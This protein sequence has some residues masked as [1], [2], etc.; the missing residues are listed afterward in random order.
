M[1]DT[2]GIPVAQCGLV[3]LADGE[4]AYIT[5]RF[6][7]INNEKI[8]VEDLCQ[9][10]EKSTSKKY[11]GS[12]EALGKVIDKYSD[13]PQD[14]KLTLF[15]TILFSFWIG[16]ADMHLKNFSLWRDP[17]SQLIRMS[18]GYDFVSTRLLIPSVQDS[19]ELALPVNGRKNKLRW[20]DFVALGNHFKIPPKVQER[21]KEK[22]LDQ[23]FTCEELIHKSFLSTSTKESFVDLLIERSKRLAQE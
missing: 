1:A 20:S 8:Q 13:Q 18:P 23:F 4:K 19:E 6:D 12:S 10:S 3:F 22:M 11:S 5:R 2:I 16:N 21:V 17:R 9:L 7:R 15:E 14:D